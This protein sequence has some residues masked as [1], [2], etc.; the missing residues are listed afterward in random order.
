MSQSFEEAEAEVQ[1]LM[2]IAGGSIDAYEKSRPAPTESGQPEQVTLEAG[3]EDLPTREDEEL[4]LKE[5]P[6]LGCGFMLGLQPGDGEPNPIGDE[7][8]YHAPSEKCGELHEVQR[9]FRLARSD[10]KA[11]EVRLDSGSYPMIHHNGAWTVLDQVKNISYREET[12]NLA[13]HRGNELFIWVYP[14]LSAVMNRP[15]AESAFGYIH[16]GYVFTR[17]PK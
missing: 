1:R 7:F 13:G 3:D 14:A 2:E 17:K 4:A 10:Q 15:P 5:E 16:R 11:R 6:D 9:A 8:S 12:G